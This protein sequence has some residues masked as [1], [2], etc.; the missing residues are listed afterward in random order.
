MSFVIDD[1]SSVDIFTL[2]LIDDD[3]RSRI[4][5]W[6]ASFYPLVGIHDF[7]KMQC[8]PS[9]V[10]NIVIHHG[11]DVF[12][13]YSIVSQNLIGVTDVCLNNKKRKS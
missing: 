8:L 7:M 9:V 6:I 11:N 13:G 2:W 1:D 3:T 4:P 10:G 5:I 12:L